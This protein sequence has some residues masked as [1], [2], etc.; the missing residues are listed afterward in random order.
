DMFQKANEEK[1]GSVM[2]V[3]P[4]EKIRPGSVM[5]RSDLYEGVIIREDYPPGIPFFVRITDCTSHYLI[6]ERISE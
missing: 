3:I 1:I 2:S 6:G 4:V 5:A